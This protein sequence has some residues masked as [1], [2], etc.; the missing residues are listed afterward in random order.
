MAT[1]AILAGGR[2]TRFG[3]TD[4]TI[5]DLAGEPMI[6]RVANRLAGHGEAVGPGADHASNVESVVDELIIN[7]RSDQRDSIS[8][9]MSG[10]PLSVSYALDDQTDLGPAAG[11]RNVCR[12][13][14]GYV[15]VV[16]CDMPFVDP[17][18]LEYLLD[19]AGGHDAVVPQLE[20][21][22]YQTTQAVYRA[23]EMAAA[24]DRAIE[25]GEHRIIAPL[26]YLDWTV[27]DRE[28]IHSIS[29]EQTF[30]NLNTRAEFDTAAERIEQER[31]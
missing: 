8:T 6:R 26:E 13:A 4:K 2:S 23:T 3:D 30:E 5:A 31:S 9:A 14:D 25:A 17:R 21:G 27:I 20:D 24:V 15:A 12:A 16:A 22:W 11:I 7:C 10:Y 1:G 18:F 29:G 28:T 19:H